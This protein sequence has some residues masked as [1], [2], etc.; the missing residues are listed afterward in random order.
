[1]FLSQSESNLTGFSKVMAYLI[2]LSPLTWFDTNLTVTAWATPSIHR[3]SSFALNHYLLLCISGCCICFCYCRR[4]LV[5][6]HCHNF[7]SSSLSLLLLVLMLILLLILSY[8][9]K[10]MFQLLSLPWSKEISCLIHVSTSFPVVSPGASYRRQ[11]LDQR[12]CL[13]RIQSYTAGTD[14]FPRGRCNGKTEG[15]QW[16]NW[17]KA[18]EKLRENNGKLQSF[19]VDETCE[20]SS[21][22]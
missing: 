3:S 5:Y 8:M 4:L 11:G 10:L 18:T 16:T 15:K 14:R 7:I 19:S 2:Q 22:G 17:G 1:M 12:R 13:G 6:C 21:W 20:Q 9:L